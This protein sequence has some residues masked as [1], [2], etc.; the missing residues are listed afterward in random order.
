MIG[1]MHELRDRL[2]TDRPSDMLGY[3][4]AYRSSY[5]VVYTTAQEVW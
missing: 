5:T 2:L 3:A 1:A 4:S